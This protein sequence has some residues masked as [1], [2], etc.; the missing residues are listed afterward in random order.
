MRYTNSAC[1]PTHHVDLQYIICKPPFKEQRSAEWILR[2]FAVRFSFFLHTK[3]YNPQTNQLAARCVWAWAPRSFLI[4]VRL[5][6]AFW[7]AA[8]SNV[9]Y[10]MRDVTYTT[11]PQHR[12]TT[13]PQSPSFIYFIRLLFFFLFPLVHIQ[14]LHDYVQ[15]SSVERSGRQYACALQIPKKISPRMN[16]FVWMQV[17]GPRAAYAFVSVCNSRWAVSCL[18][19]LCMY[20]V[21]V[22]PARSD[23]TVAMHRGT[24][25][26]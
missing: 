18:P 13:A 21:Y 2:L 8:Y 25:K 6:I 12:S 11:A 14:V 23:I 10:I 7:C 26:K 24:H 16:H 15:Y 4:F 22:H 1:T 3:C 17:C 20:I 19:F 9:K 5:S